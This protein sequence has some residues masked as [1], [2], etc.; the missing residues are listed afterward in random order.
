MDACTWIGAVA[1]IRTMADG[2]GRVALDVPDVALAQIIGQLVALRGRAVRIAIV[3]D[4][5]ERGADDD[6]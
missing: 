1:N 3:A 4:D 5:D 6:D 2:G